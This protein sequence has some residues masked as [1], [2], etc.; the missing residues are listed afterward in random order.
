MPRSSATTVR[1]EVECD[2]HG[3][4]LQLNTLQKGARKYVHVQANVSNSKPSKQ[5][6]WKTVCR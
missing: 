2:L 3:A 5:M 4:E 1:F 6:C